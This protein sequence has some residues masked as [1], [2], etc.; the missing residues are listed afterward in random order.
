MVFPGNGY[1]GQL[2]WLSNA[3]AIGPTAFSCLHDAAKEGEICLPKYI[4]IKLIS[5]QQIQLGPSLLT[6]GSF[7]LSRHPSLSLEHF[8]TECCVRHS[9][10]VVSE[11]G[12][13]SDCD[14]AIHLDQDVEEVIRKEKK[15]E[16]ISMLTGART[17]KVELGECVNVQG[18]QLVHHFSGFGEVE[19]VN[20]NPAGKE[21]DV[22]FKTVGVV[23][24]L[25]GEEHV[26]AEG[27]RLRLK[28]GSG[29]SPAPSRQQQH[30]LNPFR[31]F[32]RFHISLHHLKVNVSAILTTYLHQI[33]TT[34]SG[35]HPGSSTN[36]VA[37][38][39]R[40]HLHLLLYLTR[41]GFLL[42]ASSQLLLIY[43]QTIVFQSSYCRLVHS[44]SYYVLQACLDV[45][46]E[47]ARAC[48]QDM[49]FFE[50]MKV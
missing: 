15:E 17:L 19:N 2:S 39:L 31:Y 34:S 44:C 1:H 9:S 6:P 32:L 22:I 8:D 16:E 35:G 50:T 27:Q 33:C 12:E 13:L 5:G 14:E 43:S 49:V 11:L 25:D 42:G 40:P 10:S 36:I 30:R 20:I 23:E 7:Q 48:F 45:K 46:Y 3:A 47:E 21:A 4:S 26:L 18:E 37:E 24:Q 41:P 38:L 29:R 28:G